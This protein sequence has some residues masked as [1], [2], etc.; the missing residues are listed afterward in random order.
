M[1][2][3]AKNVASNMIVQA[4]LSLLLG[5]LLIIWPEVTAVIVVY[6]LAACIAVSGIASLVSYFRGRKDKT[7]GQGSLLVGLF[8]LIIAIVFFIFPDAVAGLFAIIFGAILVFSGLVNAFRSVGLRTFGGSAWIVMVIISVLLIVGGI[9]IIID[10]FGATATFM[11]ILGVLL[12]VKGIIDLII[13]YIT[14][15]IAKAAS[16]TR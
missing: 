5:L 11:I 12:I 1:Q 13:S 10:P 3:F 9:V 8:F 15:K 7:R 6:I 2:N 4:V 14:S 16:P